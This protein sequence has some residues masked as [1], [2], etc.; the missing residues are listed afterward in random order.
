MR[1]NAP[2]AVRRVDCFGFLFF[3]VPFFLVFCAYFYYF[4]VASHS[5]LTG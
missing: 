1:E 4:G 5:A 3:F 2:S